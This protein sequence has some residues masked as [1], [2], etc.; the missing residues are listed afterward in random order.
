MLF[1][2]NIVRISSVIARGEF[3]VVKGNVSAFN[4]WQD[5][6]FLKIED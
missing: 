3:K 4:S 6:S 5:L 2:M 1:G